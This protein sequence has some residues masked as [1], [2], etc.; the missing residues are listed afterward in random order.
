MADRESNGMKFCVQCGAPRLEG[1]A[2]CSECG[3]PLTAPS[4]THPPGVEPTRVIT[5]EPNPRPRDDV[6][7]ERVDR[8]GPRDEQAV[9]AASG[10]PVASQ[11]TAMAEPVRIGSRVAPLDVWIVL[12]CGAVNVAYFGWVTLLALRALFSGLNL[13]SAL[14]LL[15]TLWLTTVVVVLGAVCLLYVSNGLR[16]LRRDP[17]AQWLAVVLGSLFTLIGLLTLMTD[18]SD[19]WTF[20]VVITNAVLAVLAAV[21]PGISSHVLQGQPGEA[22]APV[23]AGVALSRWAAFYLVVNGLILLISAAQSAAGGYDAN[24]WRPIVG[25]LLLAGGWIVVGAGQKVLVGDSTSRVV[26]T[27]IVA[28]GA[29]LRLTADIGVSVVGLGTWIQVGLA[30]MTGVLLWLVPV[31]SDYLAPRPTA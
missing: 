14:G 6:V 24:A 27:G 9:P 31:S 17:A 8:T 12:A 23:A 3:A 15:V 2:F 16:L 10:L 28:A 30:A 1:A 21:S 5:S 25:V 18:Q 22:P 20:L 11:W 26:V 7:H 13:G 4:Q 19:R 29:I